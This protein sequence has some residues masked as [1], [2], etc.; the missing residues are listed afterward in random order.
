ML[1]LKGIM[2]DA[3]RTQKEHGFD[4]QTFPE[5]IALVHSELSEA[6]EHYRNNLMLNTELEI[7][8]K[9]DGVPVELADAVIRIAGFCEDHNI[10]LEGAIGRKMSYNRT[11]PYKH[12]NKVL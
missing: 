1:D 4:Q 5:F 9:P 2:L 6:L 3:N 10:D 12:G 8:G 7:Q 11:R